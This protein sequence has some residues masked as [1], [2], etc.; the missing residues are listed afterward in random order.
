[1]PEVQETY[2][3]MIPFKCCDCQFVQ[4][5]LRD[6]AVNQK[7]NFFC[8]GFFGGVRYCCP[9]FISG[10]CCFCFSPTITA[11]GKLNMERR[12]GLQQLLSQLFLL[13]SVPVF[14][15]VQ[16][17]CVKNCNLFWQFGCSKDEEDLTFLYDMALLN[18][19]CY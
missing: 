13:P 3:C 6:K 18:R 12:L 5:S 7:L 4:T 19:K 10:M 16:R 9:L 2:E 1:M 15:Q 14:K 8:F 17:L 11:E